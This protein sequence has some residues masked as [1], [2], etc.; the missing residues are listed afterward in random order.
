MIFT[1]IDFS[2][3]PLRKYVAPDLWRRGG[4]TRTD[5]IALVIR[6]LSLCSERIASVPFAV[7]V[8]AA[9]MA[10]RNR[11]EERANP[12]RSSASERRG[13]R[14]GVEEKLGRAA[15]SGGHSERG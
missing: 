5:R 2:H 6:S 15:G 4:S 9:G 3:I 11:S 12:A 13:G 8:A 10:R 7:W 1:E 14:H